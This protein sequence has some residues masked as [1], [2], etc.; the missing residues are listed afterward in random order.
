[1]ELQ[2][3]AENL[4]KTNVVL[5][6]H[7]DMLMEVLKRREL[8]EIKVI[9][10]EFLYQFN[11]GGVNIVV[12]SIFIEDIYLP[13][14]ALR[15]ALDQI[16]ALYNEISESQDKIMLC[17][18]YEDINEAIRNNKLG[19]L[20]SFEGLEPIGTDLNLIRIF[21][22]LGVR[23]L[24]LV[25]SRRNYVAD[26]CHFTVKE[27]GLKGGLTNFGVRVIKEAE[28]LGMFIDVSHLNDEGLRDVMKFYKGP[29]IASHSNCRK[30]SNVMRNLKD[31]DILAIASC[32]GVI[33][34][35]AF[36]PFVANEYFKRNV[37]NLAKHVD[38]IVKLSGIG[39]VGLGFDFCDFLRDENAINHDIISGHCK[40]KMLTV[41]LLK[42]GYS[43]ENIKLI[44]SGNFFRVFKSILK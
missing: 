2:V 14:M 6:A 22:E 23:G 13:E 7:F 17:K 8:G 10:R 11:E 3:R 9:E 26:G 40:I 28:K 32:G 19:I 4:H 39:S 24:G 37:E 41:E 33:G 21:Y 44:L 38:Y 30:L 15:K 27:E 34:M 25:W 35:N 43:D 42:L 20:L 1:M 18:T 31:D 36:G 12:A 16:S 5:D 29:V